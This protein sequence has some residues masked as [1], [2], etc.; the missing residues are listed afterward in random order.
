MTTR[1]AR[2][3][4]VPVTVDFEGPIGA[5]P[6][7]FST[8]LTGGGAPVIWLVEEDASAP[9]GGRVLVQRSAD[10]G[11]WMAHCWRSVGKTVGPP[12]GKISRRRLT[13]Q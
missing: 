9:A 3:V 13:A 1:I 5:P 4:D 2:S 7:G 6:A 8:A 10:A 12:S 11:A